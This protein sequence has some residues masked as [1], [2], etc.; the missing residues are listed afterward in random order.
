MPLLRRTPAPDD[1]PTEHP[2]W[3]PGRPPSGWVGRLA[4]WRRRWPPLRIARLAAAVAVSGLV[5]V[6][7][8]RGR[9]VV[10]DFELP[11]PVASDEL[12]A[13][14]VLGPDDVVHVAHPGPLVPAS[15]ATD[16][17]GRVLLTA[18]G[19]GE[20]LTET[21]LLATDL[22]P[23]RRV[24]RLATHVDTPTLML[25]GRVDVIGIRLDP[26]G[27]IERRRLVADATVAEAPTDDRGPAITVGPADDL[28]IAEWT[29]TGSL[30]LTL[31]P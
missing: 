16:P 5:V 19:A 14:H 15:V 17:V 2:V 13:G 23:D 26:F 24:V 10:P 8:L 20:L 18:I 25:G 1:A 9:S 11:V 12:P 22:D 27:A 6:P 31:R 4:L 29:A 28:T 30:S 3:R 7:A 21:R